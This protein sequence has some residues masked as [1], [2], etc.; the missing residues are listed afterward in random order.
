M[1]KSR[2]EGVAAVRPCH[3]EAEAL[4]R[5]HGVEWRLCGE[6]ERALHALFTLVEAMVDWSSPSG[7]DASGMTYEAPRVVADVGMKG[8][9]HMLL[10]KL[11]KASE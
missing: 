4:F 8:R 3:R 5:F 9:L 10:R 1:G 11:L 7:M 6:C 2:V